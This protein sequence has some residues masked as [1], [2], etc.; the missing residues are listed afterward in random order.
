MIKDIQTKEDIAKRFRFPI[1]TKYNVKV[2][3]ICFGTLTVVNFIPFCMN[4]VH[5]N[6]NNKVIYYKKI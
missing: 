1:V 6:T 2:N 4:F 5:I 3:N